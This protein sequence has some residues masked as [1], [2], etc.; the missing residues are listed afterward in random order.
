MTLA[1][2]DLRI[3]AYINMIEK[4]KHLIKGYEHIMSEGDF[5]VDYFT[6]YKESVLAIE[7]YTKLIESLGGNIS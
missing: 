6:H 3:T 1:E 5:H 7:R 2:K 4:K